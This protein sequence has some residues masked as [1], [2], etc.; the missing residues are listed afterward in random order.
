MDSGTQEPLP[1]RPAWRVKFDGVCDRCGVALLKGAVAQYDRSTRTI[2]CVVCPSEPAAQEI[3]PLE[4]GEAGGSARREYERRRSSREARV[5]ANFGN[6]LGGI[7][8]AVTSEP[9]STRAWATGARGEGIL[10]EVLA[11]VPGVIVLNDRR[12]PRSRAN[13][14]HIVI[15]PAGL[16]VI[17]AKKYKGL[18]KVRDRGGLFRRDDR[19]YVGRRDCSALVDGLARQVDAVELALDDAGVSD[20]IAVVPVLC[21]VD[22]EWP[23]LRPPTSFE[24]VRLEGKRSIKKLITSTS[25]LDADEIEPLARILAAALPPR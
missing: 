2:R 12:I 6:R 21:F 8:L 23:I 4:S 5:K 7:L 25:V 3:E 17:D 1:A 9:Q 19:L 14:D 10:G 13:I 24:G 22:G 16:F 15:G 18:I 20:D 11:N